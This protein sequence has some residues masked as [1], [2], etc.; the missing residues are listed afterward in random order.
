MKP[1]QPP[2][3]TGRVL[4]TVGVAIIAVF[5]LIYG[6]ITYTALQRESGELDRNLLRSARGLAAALEALGTDDAARASVALFRSTELQAIAG[7]ISGEPEVYVAV[8]RRDGS[9]HLPAAEAPTLPLLDMADGIGSRSEGALGLRLYVASSPRWKVALID[10]AR[11][12]SGW[13]LWSVFLELAGYLLLTLPVVLLPVWLAVRT[14]LAPL[15]R[16][17]DQVAARAPGDTQPLA[18]PRSYRELVPLQLA[19]DRLFERVAGGIAREKA[20]VHDAAHELRTPLAV[21]GTQAHVLAQAEGTARDAA[22]R[23]LHG[24]VERASHLT[25]QL[26]RLAQADALAQAPRVV[27]DVM[28]IT[29]DTLAGFAAAAQAQSTELSLSGPDSAL[30]ATDAQALRS[31]VENL[32]DNALRYGGPGGAVEVQ[33][34]LHDATWQL[35]VSDHGPGIAPEHRELAFERFW[36]GR[37]E[38][39]RGAG[40]GLAIVREAA[41]SLGGDVA[42]QDG[43]AGRGCTVVVTLPR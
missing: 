13:L 21:I 41:R 40:L 23:Q 4:G 32:V 5:V 18:L 25:H 29:R 36:R 33:A 31:I 17:S 6:F 22:R 16:L 27:V 14:G 30:L 43:P 28:D 24:A 11:R 3:L 12:R 39:A 38:R 35:R 10:D 26:L 2:S 9:L 7:D 15:R 1:R 37:S 34:P 8:S 20:F 19:L 42:V